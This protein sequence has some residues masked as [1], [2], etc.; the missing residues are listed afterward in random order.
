MTKPVETT[1]VIQMRGRI[2]PT[3]PLFTHL[4]GVAPRAAFKLLSDFAIEGHSS[5]SATK[6]LISVDHPL[7]ATLRSMTVEQAFAYLIGVT[8]KHV[9]DEVRHRDE[10][11]N[12]ARK[13]NA[14]SPSAP[15]RDLSSNPE[16]PS[17][18]H[19]PRNELELDH[20][21]LEALFAI[22]APAA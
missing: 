22:T 6:R 12:V 11:A 9:Q 18:A 2:H 14:S 21:D 8:S 5:K 10:T 7:S 15:H 16:T 20:E 17:L 4:G 1:E 13:E 3:H 19:S